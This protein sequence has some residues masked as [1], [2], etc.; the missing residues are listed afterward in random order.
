MD[1]FDDRVIVVPVR[2]DDNHVLLAFKDTN[3]APDWRRLHAQAK[4]LQGRFGLDFPA[5]AQKLERSAHSGLA[6]REA[7]RQG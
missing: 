4:D 6:Q 5:F 3:F 2:E 1:V 7:L